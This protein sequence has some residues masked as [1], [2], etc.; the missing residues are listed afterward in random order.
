MKFFVSYYNKTLVST[1]RR[2]TY[3]HTNWFIFK[4][5]KRILHIFFAIKNLWKDFWFQWIFLL[6]FLIMSRFCQLELKLEWRFLFCMEH[7]WVWSNWWFE[8][9]FFWIF[10]IYSCHHKKFDFN[11]EALG[12]GNTLLWLPCSHSLG[13]CTILRGKHGAF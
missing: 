4:L 12:H 8:E 10:L 11:E 9:I 2:T 6:I 1:W 13:T 7:I 3:Q 5:L